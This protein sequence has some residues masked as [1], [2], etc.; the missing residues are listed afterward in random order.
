MSLRSLRTAT[1]P[2]LSL[3]SPSTKFQHLS[4]FHDPGGA[5]ASAFAIRGLPTSAV[6]DTKGNV[7]GR[8]EGPAEWDSGQAKALIRH[9]MGAAGAGTQA[10]L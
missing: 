2:W 7:V 10:Q 5:L 4:L 1:L 8:I 6:I 9:Y 3:S